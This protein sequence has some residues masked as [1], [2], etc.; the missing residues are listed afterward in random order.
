M[1]ELLCDVKHTPLTRIWRVVKGLR[2]QAAQLNLFTSLSLH[3][4]SPLKVVAEE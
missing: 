1:E 4:R 3:E 2:R